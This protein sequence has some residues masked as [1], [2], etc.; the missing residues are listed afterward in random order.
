MKAK[1][2]AERGG[3]GD[4]WAQGG[5]RTAKDTKLEKGEEEQRRQEVGKSEESKDEEENASS[6][7]V[8]ASGEL[9]WLV[10]ALIFRNFFKNK[11]KGF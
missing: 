5:S 9:T 4:R 8:R 3:G 10:T 2:P 11:T 7:S 1:A 6:S